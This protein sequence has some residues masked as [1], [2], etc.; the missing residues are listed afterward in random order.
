[1][2]KTK[3][4]ARRGGP[5]AARIAAA[6]GVM[7]LCLT[8]P[9]GHTY[10]SEP[11]PSPDAVVVELSSDGVGN[12]NAGDA[13]LFDGAVLIP[14]HTQTAKLVVRNTGTDDGHL[15][16]TLID[17]NL[18]YEQGEHAVRVFDYINIS[19]AARPLA[20]D[21]R[22]AARMSDW[23]VSATAA[24]LADGHLAVFTGGL[25]AGEY[26]ELTFGLEFHLPAGSDPVIGNQAIVGLREM[27]FNVHLALSDPA[28][29]GG[30][31]GGGTGGGQAAGPGGGLT[32]TGV[33]TYYL[34]GAGVLFTAGAAVDVRRRRGNREV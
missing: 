34:V 28:A 30:G 9:I 2:R 23:M 5:F 33:S 31:A 19:V 18:N 10:A 22:P 20:A 8:L 29:I 4:T 15:V 17:T 16:A 27:N 6:L 1:M 3:S 11:A 21:N 32:N 7:F 25:P 12:G 14:G 24:E 13:A 26:V